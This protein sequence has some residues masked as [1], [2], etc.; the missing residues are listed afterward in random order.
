M[1]AMTDKTVSVPQPKS[2]KVRPKSNNS[3]AKHVK[4]NRK[5]ITDI[6]VNILDQLDEIEEMSSFSGGKFALSTAEWD[7][8]SRARESV[9]TLSELD[10][11]EVPR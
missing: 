6:A 9:E 11:E 7:C 10:I 2:S 5:S 4:L 8:I 1:A 3:H